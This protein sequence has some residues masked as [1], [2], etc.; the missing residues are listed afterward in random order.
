MQVLR[1]VSE[2]SPA[3]EETFISG[4]TMEDCATPQT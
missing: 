4:K 1:Q 3:W 2:Y